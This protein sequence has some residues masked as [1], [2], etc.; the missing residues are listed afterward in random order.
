[1][2]SREE[3]F[4]AVQSIGRGRISAQKVTVLMDYLDRNQN[5]QVEIDELLRAMDE[6]VP[7]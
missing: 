3:F 7:K 5:G 2:L 6:A 1:M 4:Q